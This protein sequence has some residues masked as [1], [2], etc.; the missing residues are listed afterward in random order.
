MAIRM[1]TGLLY[2]PPSSLLRPEGYVH[3]FFAVYV[4]STSLESSVRLSKD[5]LFFQFTASLMTCKHSCM[6]HSSF[7]FILFLGFNRVRQRRRRWYH[8]C[9][10][11]QDVCGWFFVTLVCMCT[12][13]FVGCLSLLL[14]CVQQIKRGF[15]IFF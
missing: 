15:S 4:H 3:F 14:E 9:L 11:R 7:I 5:H 2:P 13:N 6:I 1:K 8:V 10:W 12:C